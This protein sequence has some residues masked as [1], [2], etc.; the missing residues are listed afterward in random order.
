MSPE[1]RKGKARQT[2]SGNLESPE[3]E[4]I[5]KQTFRDQESQ[6]DSGDSE[7]A[8]SLSGLAPFLVSEANQTREVVMKVRSTQTKLSSK[9]GRSVSVQAFEEEPFVGLLSKQEVC[10]MIKVDRMV[11][12]GMRDHPEARFDC[13]TVTSKRVMVEGIVY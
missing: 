6:W 11:G 12:L 5:P 13:H 3:S 10:D 2:G 7:E 4:G 8:R 9:G 1:P